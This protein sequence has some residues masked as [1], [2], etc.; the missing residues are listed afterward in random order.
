M[1]IT[2]K[3]NDEKKNIHFNFL[4]LALLIVLAVTLH[5]F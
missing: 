2:T 4:S 3:D 5:K 1:D